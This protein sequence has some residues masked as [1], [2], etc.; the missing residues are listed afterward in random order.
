MIALGVRPE[1][2]LQLKIRNIR[3]RDGLLCVFIGEDGDDVIKSE[4]SRR[5]LPVPQLLLDLGFREWA[6][7]L[8][9]RGEIW[10]FPEIEPGSATGRRSQIFGDRMRTLLG[11]LDLKFSDEDIYAMRRTLASKLLH[12][13]VD[14]GIR[15][16]VLGHLEGTTIDRHY[17]DDGLAELKAL[18]DQVDYGVTVGS[19]PG[20]AYPVITGCSRPMLPSLDVTVAL[21]DQSELLAVRLSDPDTEEVIFAGRIEGTSPPREEG[22]TDIAAISARTVADEILALTSSY[23]LSLPS[24]EEQLA[25]LEHLLMLG[26]PPRAV[27]ALGAERDNATHQA[28]VHDDNSP[29]H[30]AEISGDIPVC[31]SFAVGDLI[32][33]ALPLSRRGQENAAPRPGLVIGSR[34]LGGRRYLDIAWGAPAGTKHPAPHELVVVG[35]S[36]IAEAQLAAATHFDLRRRYLIPED[37]RN[38]LHRK[39]GRLASH[40]R[41]RLSETLCFAGDITPTPVAMTASTKMALVIERRIPKRAVIPKALRGGEAGS[42]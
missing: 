25:A 23:S 40:A 15:Q 29:A 31:G 13:R 35:P 22:W 2:I 36:E 20:F 16:R 6:I 11:H 5:V 28:I 3:R 18:L 38:R 9:T 41:K 7:A 4:Q 32:I 19:V 10:A 42:R 1:E 14:T 24:N 8:H 12:L 34:D 26:T 37:D 27:P 39:L 17:S 30:S 33:C 21:G